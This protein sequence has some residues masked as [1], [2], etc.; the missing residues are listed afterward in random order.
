M[1]NLFP[2]ESLKQVKRYFLWNKKRKNHINANSLIHFTEGFLFC[3][4]P[5]MT[6][7]KNKTIHCLY[8]DFTS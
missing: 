5:C 7:S 8:F 3:G 4:I 6:F 2:M 1:L